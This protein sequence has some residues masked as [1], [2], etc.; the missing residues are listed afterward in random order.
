[1][2]RAATWR[3]CFRHS[4]PACGPIRPALPASPVMAGPA[5]LRLRWARLDLQAG[6]T[7][8]AGAMP[9]A[10]AVAHGAG[11]RPRRPHRTRR[12]A[13]TPG[14]LQLMMGS[15]T[16]PAQGVRGAM[17][18]AADFLRRRVRPSRR[19]PFLSAPSLVAAAPEP[20]SGTLAL[21]GLAGLLIFGGSR[22]R[23]CDATAKG[24]DDPDRSN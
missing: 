8:R 23:R 1:M 4:P 5:R 2:S 13:L 20:D 9:A 16:R 11:R 3:R 22:V 6:Q 14:R 24:G 12:R 10:R 19:S 15:R 18:F 21:S 7:V 17:G